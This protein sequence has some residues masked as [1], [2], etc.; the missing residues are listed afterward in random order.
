MLRFSTPKSPWSASASRRQLVEQ[1]LGLFQIERV[2]AFGEPAIDRSEKI[3]GLIP[4]ALIAP[5][6]RA[7]LIAARSSKPFA[8]C[9][10]AT[11]IAT[12]SSVSP[13]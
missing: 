10:R 12:C 8:A 4:L 13:A 5:E 2:E 9:C 7:M 3:A 11:R 1:L 6:R